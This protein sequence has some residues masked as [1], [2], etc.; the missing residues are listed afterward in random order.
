MNKKIVLFL[1]ISL[2]AI[3]IV[4]ISISTHKL[5]YQV[6]KDG[7]DS[8]QSRIIS[9]YQEYWDFI[10]HIDSEN[11]AYGNVFSF[12]PNSYNEQYFNKK[13]LAILNIVTGSGMNKLNSIDI[14]VSG[15]T[16]VCN[17]NIDY[18]KS[19]IVTADMHGKV[20][21]VE[22]NKSIKNFKINK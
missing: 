17:A 21:L 14:F 3:L 12:N 5:R 1:T 7:Y 2:I 8:Y 9:N 22:I 19:S 18:A 11:R 6:I 15:D 16:L 13:S 4:V 10:K 20:I